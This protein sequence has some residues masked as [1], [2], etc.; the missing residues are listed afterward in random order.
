MFTVNIGDFNLSCDSMHEVMSTLDSMFDISATD[1]VNQDIVRN[2][3][4]G[5]EAV[6]MTGDC[7]CT[8]T[9]K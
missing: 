4:E 5:G 7:H 2:L 1:R 8:V 3:K 6:F 9:R